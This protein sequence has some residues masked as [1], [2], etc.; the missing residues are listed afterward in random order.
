MA[1]RIK[2][3]AGIENWPM[4]APLK[5]AGHTFSELDVVVVTLFDGV[6]EGRGKAAADSL[7][8]TRV[9]TVTIPIHH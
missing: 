5:I 4:I 9:T 7:R 1:D 2:L 6:H 3:T 8:A